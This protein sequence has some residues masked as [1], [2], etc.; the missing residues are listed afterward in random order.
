MAARRRHPRSI[1]GIALWIATILPSLIVAEVSVADQCPLTAALVLNDLQSGVVGQTG[2]VWT[3]APDCSF[4]VAR[5]IALSTAEPHRRGQL[6]AEQQSRLRDLLAR[7]NPNA[8][9]RQIG[10][11]Q[12]NGRQILLTYGRAASSLNLPPGPL[13]A[14]VGDPNAARLLELANAIKD[15][16]GN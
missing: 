15:M 3:L 10:E 12:V 9:P 7:I 8:L 11:P 13:R 1:V 2:T 5:R 14:T 16:I 4:S 6:T